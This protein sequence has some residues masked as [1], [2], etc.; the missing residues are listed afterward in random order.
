[1]QRPVGVLPHRRNDGVARDGG[2][3]LVPHK[4]MVY[5]VVLIAFSQSIPCPSVRQDRLRAAVR[6]DEHPRVDDRLRR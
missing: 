2:S 5:L 6:V 1:M 3:D 4:N